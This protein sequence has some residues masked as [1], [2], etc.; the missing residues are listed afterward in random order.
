MLFRVGN[1]N[2]GKRVTRCRDQ[3]RETEVFE[4]CI[5]LCAWA[6]KL[7]PDFA[8]PAFGGRLPF[9]FHSFFYDSPSSRVLL[10]IARRKAGEVD[11]ESR[12]ATRW[13][14]IQLLSD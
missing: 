3:P 7:P 5:K 9:L 1:P 11:D 8:H 4:F 10:S 13:I 2:K 12:G 14:V 6:L